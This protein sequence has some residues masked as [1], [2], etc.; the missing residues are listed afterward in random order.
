MIKL[1]KSVIKRLYINNFLYFL[2]KI[3][4]SLIFIVLLFL[5]SSDVLAREIDYF[6]KPQIGFWFGISTPVYT[7]YDS[8]AKALTGGGFFRSNTRP[9]LLKFIEM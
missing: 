8:V 5:F 6:N 9:D 2:N 4:I 3:F 7:T 1:L